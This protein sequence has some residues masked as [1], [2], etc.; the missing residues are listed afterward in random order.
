M[1]EQKA[2]TTNMQ[3]ILHEVN[4]MQKSSKNRLFGQRL[5]GG[6]NRASNWQQQPAKSK[7]KR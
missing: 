1:Q 7:G 2:K 6:D 4:F 3:D 5:E